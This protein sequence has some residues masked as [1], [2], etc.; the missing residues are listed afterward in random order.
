[1][2]SHAPQTILQDSTE[3]L[4][5]SMIGRSCAYA[6]LSIVVLGGWFATWFVLLGLGLTLALVAPVGLIAFSMIPASV[7]RT[8]PA[9]HAPEKLTLRATRMVRMRDRIELDDRAWSAQFS[10][11][12][13]RRIAS[14]ESSPR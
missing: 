14:A 6:L 11:P 10:R 12:I 9:M 7:R 2:I 4:D 8:H 13:S 1:M 3:K 5:V